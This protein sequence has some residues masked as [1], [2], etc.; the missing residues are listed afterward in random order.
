MS[1]LTDEEREAI[2]HSNPAYMTDSCLAFAKAFETAVINK[3]NAGIELPTPLNAMKWQHNMYTADQVKVCI[4]AARYKP[5]FKDF[6][7]EPPTPG[8]RILA[9]SPLYPKGDPMRFR[10]VTV[11]PC[12]M[13]EIHSYAVETDLEDG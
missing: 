13:L 3:L 1:L 8:T 12:E 6:K 7:K 5:L 2:Q 4:A 10:L 9:F 11:L